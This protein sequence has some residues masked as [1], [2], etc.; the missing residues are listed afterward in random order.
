MSGAIGARRRRARTSAS[1]RGGPISPPSQ[2]RL[3]IDSTGLVIVSR[4]A[5][6]GVTSV[7]IL[8]LAKDRKPPNSAYVGHRRD[9]Q[10]A[11]SNVALGLDTG[12][13]L[14]VIRFH[15]N[16]GSGCSL[17]S[18]S[19]PEKVAFSFINLPDR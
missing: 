11:S 1:D 18:L 2:L 17:G 3:R 12:P 5:G 8:M 13:S 10:S 14:P 15:R 4:M 6:I 16:A 9:G 7:L 19:Y